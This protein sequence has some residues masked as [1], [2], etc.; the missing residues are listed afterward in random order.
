MSSFDNLTRETKVPS[1][2]TGGTLESLVSQ[3]KQ[4][5]E[6]REGYRGSP[7]DANIT[8][9]ELAKA[10]LVELKYGNITYGGTT[11]GSGPGG[12]TVT[13]P[14]TG[15][16]DLTP[17]PQPTG[18]VAASAVTTVILEWSEPPGYTNL[19]YTEIW[20]SADS[21]LAN[22]VKIGSTNAFLYADTVGPASP[23]YHY[24][25]RFVSTADVP[26][27]YSVSQ[28]AGTTLIDTEHIEDLA[29]TNAKIGNLAVDSAQIA[30]LAVVEAKIGAL[31]VTDAKIALA[32][33]TGAKIANATITD[34]N[35]GLATITGAKIASATITDANIGLAEITGAKIA[36]ATIT[37]ANIDSLNADKITAGTLAAGRIAAGSITGSHI[38]ASTI[39]AGNIAA[40]QITADKMAADSIT[41]ANGA[42]AN[43]AVTTLKIGDNAVTVPVANNGGSFWLNGVY[44]IAVAVGA[45]MTGQ[46]VFVHATARMARGFGSPIATTVRARLRLDSTELAVVEG[47]VPPMDDSGGKATLSFAASTFSVNGGQTFY[48]ELMTD[49]A[50]VMC[51]GSTIFAL[52]TRK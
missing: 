22:A 28:S 51:E 1:I 33:I 21:L 47:Y 31:A 11:G 37:D 17:P 12:T 30:D 4:I 24:W 45:T 41:A 6:V 42:I 20:R 10:G 32:T 43:L 39:L 8:W 50:N 16:S 13:P 25:V 40:D 26:G 27:T 38:A 18:L 34:A 52:E 7:L 23:T 46:R 2:Q 9:R 44:A 5:L 48:L 36:N 49:G 3:L 29:I 19:A 15:E 35:I 14:G